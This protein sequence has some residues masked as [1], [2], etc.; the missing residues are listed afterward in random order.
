MPEGALVPGRVTHTRYVKVWSGKEK[1]LVL[2][3][4]GLGI[5]LTTRSRKTIYIKTPNGGQFR[6]SVIMEATVGRSQGQGV[7]K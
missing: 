7:S 2:Q 5:R 6:M 3:V 4:W 1:S